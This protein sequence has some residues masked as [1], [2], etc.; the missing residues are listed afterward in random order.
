MIPRAAHYKS[1]FVLR[2]CTGTPL[3]QDAT[4]T[5][6]NERS[7]VYTSIFEMSEILLNKFVS[8]AD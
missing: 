7:H 6:T 8:H 1:W 5:A 2:V 3:L 4:A